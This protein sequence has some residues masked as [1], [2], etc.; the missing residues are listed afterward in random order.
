VQRAIFWLLGR[1]RYRVGRVPFALAL[2]GYT[3]C[4]TANHLDELEHPGPFDRFALW[5]ADIVSRAPFFTFCVLLVVVWLPTYPFVGKFDTWQ[6]LINTP[7]T[8]LTFLLVAVLQNSQRRAERALHTKV[9]A[10]ADGLADLMEHFL[11]SGDDREDDLAR[12]VADLKRVVG[13]E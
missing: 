1:R 13:L 8:V 11:P 10:I 7:T 6:L 4:M 9:D 5:A 2:G 12:D 3:G